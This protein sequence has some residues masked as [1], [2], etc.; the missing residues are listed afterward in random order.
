MCSKFSVIKGGGG[1]NLSKLKIELT[2]LKEEEEDE[3]R[4]GGYKEGVI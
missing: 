4:G 1:I 3:E 2:D